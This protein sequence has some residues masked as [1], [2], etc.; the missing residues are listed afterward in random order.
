MPQQQGEG[1]E[2]P[3]R[4][5]RYTAPT[6]MAEGLP[7]P[8]PNPLCPSDL[9]PP[10]PIQ[11]FPHAYHLHP[12][13]THT[14]TRAY[15]RTLKTQAYDLQ[16]RAGKADVGHR[17]R[18]SLLDLLFL[19]PHVPTSHMASNAMMQVVKHRNTQKEQ[20]TLR[21]GL[22]DSPSFSVSPSPLDWRAS[23]VPNIGFEETLW[24]RQ[25][26]TVR[27]RA[28]A[29][30]P[31][32]RGEAPRA[33]SCLP[34]SLFSARSYS[35]SG[36]LRRTID[37][38]GRG[39]LS[40]KSPSLWTSASPALSPEPLLPLR[41]DASLSP[42]CTSAPATNTLPCS[43]ASFLCY[44]QTTT[45][46]RPTRTNQSDGLGGGRALDHMRSTPACPEAR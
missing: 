8:H 18:S 29:K 25:W 24:K 46:D 20:N 2:N 28:Q 16:Y 1:E 34:R 15:T 13:H 31:Q 26:P 33:S 39:H 45:Q 12:P 38:R 10:P 14:R 41:S 43:A 3:H 44:D 40:A 6:S 17:T 7:P 4:K 19:S 32:E 21:T 22:L 35:G 30:V 42:P 11:S 27:P 9:I 36:N 5:R 37:R 23:R